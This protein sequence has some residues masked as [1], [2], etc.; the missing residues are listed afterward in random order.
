MS[1]G[2]PSP[3]PGL[4]A[5]L[6]PVTSPR[7]P[8]AHKL[9]LT[10]ALHLR[11]SASL[12]HGE[13]LNIQGLLG[14]T[15]KHVWGPERSW[16][17]SFLPFQPGPSVSCSPTLLPGGQEQSGPRGSCCQ[18][19]GCGVSTSELRFRREAEPT[20][21]RHM[22]GKRWSSRN[23][24]TWIWRLASPK[25]QVA[26]RLETRKER[27]CRLLAEFPLVLP[28]GKGDVSLCSYPAV[29]C[30]G[31]AHP[32]GARKSALPTFRQCKC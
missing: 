3:Q 18:P 28:G 10:C 13:S 19:R 2:P 1:D 14:A 25:P 9:A 5:S 29:N 15:N 4:L 32:H 20:E 26:G 8:P 23:G 11:C 12:G 24:L 7:S 22:E 16:P 31:K 21:H 17:D 27:S 6:L 30:L